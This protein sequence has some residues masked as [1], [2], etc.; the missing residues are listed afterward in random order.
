M[1]SVYE[2]ADRAYF[3]AKI[4]D[5]KTL[6]WRGV[7][8]P[9]RKDSHAGKRNALLWA[10]ERDRIGRESIKLA[11]SE[12]WEA[13]VT[14]WLHQAFGY[15][16]HTQIRYATAWAH[17]F[18]FLVAHEIRLPR[19]LLY[20]HAFEY[21]TWRTTQLRWCGK[22]INHNTALTETK[23]MSRIMEEARRREFVQANPWMR[24][25]IRRQNVTH[26]KPMSQHEIDRVR[27]LL[28]Q[29]EGSRPITER[30]MTVSFEVALLQAVRLSETAVPMGRVH[31]DERTTEKVNLDRIT[32]EVK[33]ARGQRRTKTLPVNPALRPLL[34]ALRAAG[35]Q[36]TCELPQ[37]AAKLWWAFRQR[38]GLEHLRF[39]STRSTAATELA[40][41]GV[42]QQK[43]KEILGHKSDAVHQAYLHFDAGDLADAMSRLAFSKSA[44]LGNA[45]AP[46]P[47]R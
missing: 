45:G 2:R 16:R 8:T 35:A 47:T 23:V 3:Y 32:F 44:P 27:A 11:R 1:A 40:N 33:G 20:R 5:A 39:H 46:A 42:P 9:F 22:T 6:K 38:H 17:L 14:P 19:E 28:R 10:A 37:M 31:L 30:W 4:R 18:E 43:A 25:G 36:A 29:E 24:L 26:A 21:M 34:L 15:N 13:W 41:Q 12:L 7:R